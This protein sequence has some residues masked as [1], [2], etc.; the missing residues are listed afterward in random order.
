V[1]WGDLGPVGRSA[2]YDEGGADP[3]LAV[4]GG[5]YDRVEL[6]KDAPSASVFA[7]RFHQIACGL[8]EVS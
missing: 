2:S 5:V 7:E 8:I 6:R 4:P 3:F 1:E